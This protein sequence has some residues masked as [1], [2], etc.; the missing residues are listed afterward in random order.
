[1]LPLRVA[2]TLLQDGGTSGVGTADN[3]IA[4]ATLGTTALRLRVEDVVLHR[5]FGHKSQAAESTVAG[6]DH[7][8]YKSTK[9]PKKMRKNRRSPS[10]R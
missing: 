6:F 4:L 7:L 1:M 5:T 8:L 9:I 3:V 10:I 2:L